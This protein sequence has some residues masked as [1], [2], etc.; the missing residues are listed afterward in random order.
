MP[1]HARCLNFCRWPIRARCSLRLED[2]PP[3]HLAMARK[4]RKPCGER[5]V[6]TPVYAPAAIPN[7]RKLKRSS[8]VLEQKSESTPKCSVEAGNNRGDPGCARAKYRKTGGD[9]HARQPRYQHELLSNWSQ[10]AADSG[11]ARARY[12][13]TGG[14]SQGA[15]GVI[16]M[17]CFPIGRSPHQLRN[18]YYDRLRESQELRRQP[19]AFGF[20]GILRMAA[21]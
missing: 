15:T 1:G 7:A 13:K 21:S 16:D 8:Q 4:G 10:D 17:S 14:D 2:M 12:R 6:G 3:R 20:S 18:G 5:P 11:C 19:T 9:S